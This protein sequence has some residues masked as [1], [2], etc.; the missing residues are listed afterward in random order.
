MHTLTTGATE[1]QPC[2]S[3]L[4]LLSYFTFQQYTAVKCCHGKVR[5]GSLCTFVELQC[6]VQLSTIYTYLGR[7]VKWLML[8]TNNEMWSFSTNF[9]ERPQYKISQQTVRWEP[10]WY[11]RIDSWTDMTM[12]LGAF[13]YLCE[14]AEKCL[15]SVQCAPRAESVGDDTPHQCSVTTPKRMQKNKK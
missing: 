10:R 6:F 13:R 15:G 8:S 7:H 1:T 9:R 12:V 4:L 5:M 14:Y 3:F 2:L 11:L